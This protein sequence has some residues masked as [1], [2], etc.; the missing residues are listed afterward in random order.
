MKPHKDYI[1]TL[2]KDEQDAATQGAAAKPKAQPEQPAP[3][4]A[5]PDKNHWAYIPKS[6]DDLFELPEGEEPS[7][8][9]YPARI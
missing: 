4:N 1:H 3:D 7:R 8:D 6:S 9:N 5:K 2:P